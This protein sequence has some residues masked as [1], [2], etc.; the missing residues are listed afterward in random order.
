MTIGTCFYVSRKGLAAHLGLRMGCLGGLLDD[1]AV[2]EVACGGERD[3]ALVG[4]SAAGALKACG[5]LNRERL[6]ADDRRGLNE[7]RVREGTKLF[8]GRISPGLRS[9]AW[10]RTA[11]WRSFR[12]PW[13]QQAR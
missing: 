12:F 2:A 1:N 13:G 4:R 5:E 11:H 8:C 7:S 10:S 6:R 3:E 9:E